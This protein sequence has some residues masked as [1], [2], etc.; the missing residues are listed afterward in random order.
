MPSHEEHCKHSFERYGVRGDDIHTWIDEP[1]RIYG[2]SHRKVRHGLDD[3]DIAVK[4]FGAKY[5]DDMVRNI[6]LDHQFLDSKEK[7]VKQEFQPIPIKQIQPQQQITLSQHAFR[8]VIWFFII[9][10]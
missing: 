8:A 1:C 7:S 3:L 2:V 10:C 9:G 5:G 6:Y 4:T